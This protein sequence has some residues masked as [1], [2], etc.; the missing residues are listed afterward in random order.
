MPC[1]LRHPPLDPPWVRGRALGNLQWG[2]RN[3]QGP[4]LAAS[5]EKGGRSDRFQQKQPDVGP[6]DTGC[7]SS[8]ASLE[9][10]GSL[11][12]SWPGLGF[13]SASGLSPD[14]LRTVL[15]CNSES[16]ALVGHH[17]AS[18]PALQPENPGPP[19]TG[20]QGC[21]LLA[22]TQDGASRPAH[23]PVLA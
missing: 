15:S 12:D 3:P 11:R 10:P 23:G 5:A 13:P 16:G 6:P 2:G 17:L 19:E 21:P 1:P 18:P 22:S 14:T 7:L 4:S 20:V 9:S 8:R